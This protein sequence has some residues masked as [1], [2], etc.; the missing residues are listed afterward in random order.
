MSIQAQI[1]S[2]Y[3]DIKLNLQESESFS[4][5]TTD[6]GVPYIANSS[7]N[8]SIVYYFTDGECFMFILV[9]S[10]TEGVNALINLF[11]ETYV[12]INGTEWESYENGYIKQIK[13]IYSKDTNMMIFIVSLKDI[14]E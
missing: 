6:E 9:P 11:N 7:E 12:V 5:G 1:G 13:L 2:S 10:T 14:I 3:D 8:L 4:E